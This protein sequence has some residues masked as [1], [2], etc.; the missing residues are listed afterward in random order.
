MVTAEHPSVTIRR[1]EE[2]DLQHF[3][4]FGSER[5]VEHCRATFG[6]G[7]PILVAVD[8][9]DVPVAKV[10][11]RL[12]AEREA[13]WI[14]AAAVMPELQ[15]RGIGTALIRAAEALA[16]ENGFPAVELGVEDSNPAARRLYERLDYRSVSR[17]DF[18]Y[19]GAPRPNPGVLMRKALA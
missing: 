5:H 7:V 8:A 17:M 11:V 2:R 6:E 3:A 19:D 10:H 15:R 1:C 13:A 4:A 16:A 9:Y 14:E 18:V 12:D